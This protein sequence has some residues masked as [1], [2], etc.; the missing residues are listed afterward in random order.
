MEIRPIKVLRFLPCHTNRHDEAGTPELG[1]PPPLDGRIGIDHRDHD[2]TY[3]RFD[4]R[5]DTGRGS[6]LVMAAGFEG[7]EEGCALG[8]T[9]CLTKGEDF[10]VGLSRPLVVPATD[11]VL[12]RHD[13]RADHRIRAGLAAPFRRETKSHGHE[14]TVLRGGGHR[15]LRESRER[16]CE[17]LPDPL[18]LTLDVELAC[19]RFL[20]SP[21]AKAAWAAASLAIATR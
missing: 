9:A 12:L 4:Y 19:V 21:S 2:T 6:F 18:D 16:R 11:D 5:R 3:S 17:V 7:N 1:K 14:V 15:F 10:S 8:P 20:A 13:E